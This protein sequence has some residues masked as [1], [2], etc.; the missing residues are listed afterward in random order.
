MAGGTAVLLTLAASAED[1]AVRL[2]L[3]GAFARALAENPGVAGARTQVE[4]AESLRQQAFS[5]VL[6][7]VSASGKATRNDRE[8]SFG[9]GDDVRV[10]LPRNDWSYRLTLH[11]PIFAGLREKRA[12]DQ[13]K[14]GI[15]QAREG[16]AD[17][18]NLL[19]LKVGSDYLTVLEA[20]ALAKVEE[21]NLELAKR[22]LQQAT[23]FFEVGEVTRVDVLRAEAGIKAA[24]RQLVVA[25]AQRAAAAGQLRISLALDGDIEVAPADAFLPP[26]P[27][28]K[29]LV[30]RASAATPAVRQGELEVRVAELEVKK[31]KGAYLPVVSADG[32]WVE[33]RSSF[34]SDTYGYFSVNLDLPIY[35][36]GEVR[37]RVREAEQQLHLAQL[38]LEDLRRN[39]QEQMRTALLDVTTAHTLL[40]LSREEVAAAEREYQESFE[41]YRAQEATALDLETAELSLADARRRVASA[42]VTVQQAELRVWYLA[43]DLKNAVMRPNPEEEIPS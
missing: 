31:R 20:E 23:D 25:Q 12:Y 4:I 6:P 18:Q 7:R 19:L 16:L 41:L 29:E 9:S 39:L 34:P 14:L 13:S 37:A 35:Q 26:L 27:D 11:Q 32:G 40:D 2:T 42:E 38:Q 30:R 33:Q 24:E 3:Q 22:R 21:R 5:L 10:V 15:D 43:G 1:G 8:V 28:E 17:T 36:G